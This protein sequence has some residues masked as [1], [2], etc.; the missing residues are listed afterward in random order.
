MQYLD[1]PL[2]DGS[3][4]ERVA[5]A[6]VIAIPP[7]GREKQSRLSLANDEID[8]VKDGIPLIPYNGL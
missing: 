5:V 7:V 1:S 6:V 3:G 2:C 4:S 8:M